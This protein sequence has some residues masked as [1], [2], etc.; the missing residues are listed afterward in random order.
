MSSGRIDKISILD[1]YPAFLIHILEQIIQNYE[2]ITSE[3]GQ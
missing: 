3:P 1:Y 2:A